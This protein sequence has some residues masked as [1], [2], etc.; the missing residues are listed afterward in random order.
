MKYINAAAN[1]TNKR[2]AITQFCGFREV[3]FSH[4]PIDGPR[5]KQKNF[6]KNSNFRKYTKTPVYM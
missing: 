5:I 3:H 6:L 2:L 4:P 1:G